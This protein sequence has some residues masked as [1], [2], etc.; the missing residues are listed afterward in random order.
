M[1]KKAAEKAHFKK[2]VKERLGVDINRVNII[3][4]VNDIMSGDNVIQSYKITNRKSIYDII[5][6]KT[7]CFVFF[8]HN[9]RVP[10]TVYSK[11]MGI[12]NVLK[13]LEDDNNG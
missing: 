2:R 7:R 1:D 10:I 12:E 9:R 6:M 8:D 13:K 11:D 3:N 4:L 5:F